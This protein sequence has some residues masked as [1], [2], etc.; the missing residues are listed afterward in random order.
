MTRTAIRPLTPSFFR[1]KTKILLAA[2]ILKRQRELLRSRERSQIGQ[3][4]EN[5]AGSG[6]H[7]DLVARSLAVNCQP[8]GGEL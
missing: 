6:I 7:R 5:A 8:S 4:M 3:A 1:P 2:H